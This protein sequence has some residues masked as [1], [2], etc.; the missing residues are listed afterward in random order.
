MTIEKQ[1]LKPDGFCPKTLETFLVHS[2]VMLGGHDSLGAVLEHLSA[3]KF[4]LALSHMKVLKREAGMPHS[5]FQAVE[6][7]VYAAICPHH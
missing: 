4:A 1:G 7:Q 3:G 2:E 5:L 6:H